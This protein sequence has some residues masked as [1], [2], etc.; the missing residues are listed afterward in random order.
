[1][2]NITIILLKPM[3]LLN[4]IFCNISSHLTFI[5]NSSFIEIT[6]KLFVSTKFDK[7]QQITFGDTYRNVRDRETFYLWKGV[8]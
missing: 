3:Y 1:M 5:E 2:H 4:P 8:G 7:G 6:L